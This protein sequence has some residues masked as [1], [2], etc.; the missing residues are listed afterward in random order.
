MPR[1]NEG[2]IFGGEEIRAQSRVLDS[3]YADAFDC[4]AFIE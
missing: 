2:I 1:R 4:C 3:S